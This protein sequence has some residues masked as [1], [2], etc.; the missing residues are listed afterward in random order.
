MVSQT[1]DRLVDIGITL[2]VLIIAT[3]ILGVTNYRNN[4]Q[5]LEVFY[6]QPASNMAVF[7]QNIAGTLHFFSSLD[8]AQAVFPE[9]DAKVNWNNEA[10]LIYISYPQPSSGYSLKLADG[11]QQGQTVLFQYRIVP[12]ASDRAYLTVITQPVLVVAINR[13]SLVSTSPLIFRFQDVDSN[14]TTSLTV[15]PNETI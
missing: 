14:Q 1:K 2:V 12:P 8:E 9:F 3:V 7:D 6:R 4:Q 13:V 10:A 11:T 5:N 15:L